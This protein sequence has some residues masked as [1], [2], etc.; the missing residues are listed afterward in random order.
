MRDPHV[1]RLFYRL[2]PAQTVTYENPPPVHCETYAFRAK[3]DQGVLTVEMK[4]HHPT[5]QSARARTGEWLQ[6]WEIDS[7]LR[8]GSGYVRFGFERSDV[9]DRDPP[10]PTG[11]QTIQVTALESAGCLGLATVH[12]TREDYPSPPNAFK[13]S[14]DVRTMW[15]R[16][17]RYKQGKELLLSM[18]NFCLSVFEDSTREKNGARKAAARRYNVDMKILGEI[19]ELAAKRGSERDA[20]KSKGAGEEW[21][22]LSPTEVNWIEGAV[23][24]LIRRKGEYDY[25]PAAAASLP[26]LTLS[27]LPKL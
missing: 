3:L 14:D 1:E 21:K 17:Q 16:Y 15:N 19:G 23:K 4:E 9:I 7:E 26:K 25:D 2:Q 24:L 27:D 20:R 5:E 18:A 12:V 10:P 22:P 6:A 11:D 8:Y 13:A